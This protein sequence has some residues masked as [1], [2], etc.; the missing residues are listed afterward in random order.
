MT[1][2]L[3]IGGT[4]GIGKVISE[5]LEIRGDTVYTAS[6]TKYDKINHIE[7]DVKN[8]NIGLLTKK[9]KSKIK[10]LIFS[11]RYRGNSLESDFHITVKGVIDTVENIVY[12]LESEASVVIIGSVA[13]R[14]VCQEQPV[15]YHATR[16]SLESMVKF[17][18]VKYG[19]FGIR[20]NCILPCTVI[21]PENEHFFTEQNDVRRMIERITPLKKMGTAQD[22]ANLVDF[23]CS[24]RSTFITG[25]SF[26]LDGG[27]SLVYQESMAREL[28]NLNHPNSVK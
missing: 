23:L 28:L 26:L 17:Y 12:N 7:F 1:N 13:G 24:S 11:H 22:I 19:N 5:H 21:K 20:F 6:R 8:V 3:V 2:T 25:N 4:R 27:L 15:I 10:Y 14:L 16:A 9:I 18:A